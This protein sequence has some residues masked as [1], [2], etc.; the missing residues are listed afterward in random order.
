MAA[1][2]FECFEGRKLMEKKITMFKNLFGKGRYKSRY[3]RWRIA[4]YKFAIWITHHT[5]GRCFSCGKPTV[6]LTVIYLNGIFCGDCSKRTADET[7]LESIKV[8]GEN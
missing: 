4:I 2:F 1:T 5:V 6:G 8:Q 7:N 3:V